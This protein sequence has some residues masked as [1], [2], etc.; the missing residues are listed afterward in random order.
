M[1][2]QG[3]E[4][5]DREVPRWLLRGLAALTSWLPEPP[6][7][8]TALALLGVEVTINDEKAR[9]ELGYRS[10]VGR[11]QSLRAMAAAHAR[12]G[13]ATSSASRPRASNS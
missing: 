3:V 11:E 6:I 10:K 5:G 12:Q 1:R 4:P 2:T 13:S 7:T 8:K 9:R